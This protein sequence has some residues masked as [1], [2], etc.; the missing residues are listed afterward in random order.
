MLPPRPRSARSERPGEL[1]SI[2]AAYAESRGDDVTM[3]VVS[4]A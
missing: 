4:D 3:L 2:A 1:S